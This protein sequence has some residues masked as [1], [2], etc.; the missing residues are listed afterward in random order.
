V[1]LLDSVKLEIPV[2]DPL[3][4]ESWPKL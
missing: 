3:E 2:A 1:N 4:D